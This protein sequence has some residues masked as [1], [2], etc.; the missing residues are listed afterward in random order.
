MYLLNI[1]SG[2]SKLMVTPFIGRGN[3]EG[4]EEIWRKD[5]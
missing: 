1:L 2:A 3:V 4:D 5:Y